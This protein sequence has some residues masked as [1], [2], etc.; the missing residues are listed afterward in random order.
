MGR[1]LATTPRSRVR[2]ALRQV[3]LRSRERAAAIK[4]EKNTCQCCHRKGSKAKGKEV[5]IQV[6]HIDMIDWDGVIDIIFERILHPPEKYKVLCKECHDNE[7]HERKEDN[8]HICTTP[9]IQSS[10][11]EIVE[12]TKT[13]FTHGE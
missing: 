6:H 8:A 11:G 10:I 1:K 12:M 5:K 13:K 3:W 9:G 7:D 4:R 2:S